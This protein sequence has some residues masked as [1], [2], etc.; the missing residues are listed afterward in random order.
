MVVYIELSVGWTRTCSFDSVGLM[1]IMKETEILGDC[2]V[3]FI[4]I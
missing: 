4:I 3:V 2:F 1:E